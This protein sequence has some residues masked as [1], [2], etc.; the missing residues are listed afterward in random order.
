MFT[1]AT[2]DLLGLP[3]S[4][5]H[6]NVEWVGEGRVLFSMTQLGDALSCHFAADKAGLRW[7]KQAI[8]EFCSC[9]FSWF[10]WCKMIIA[11]INKPSVER[12]VRKCG[13]SRFGTSGNT[14]M[15]MRQR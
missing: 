11:A 1:I 14:L 9:A 8:E 4:D 5:N 2:G 3:T 7:I 13:F 12:I 15:Y 6:I 10:G